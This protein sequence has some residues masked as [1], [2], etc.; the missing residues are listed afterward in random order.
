M[1]PTETTTNGRP[2]QTVD[3]ME[4]GN[5]KI[6]EFIEDESQAYF[7]MIVHSRCCFPSRQIAGLKFAMLLHHYFKFRRVPACTCTNPDA[8]LCCRVKVRVAATMVVERL[9]KATNLRVKVAQ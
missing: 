8:T 7:F 4:V 1:P 9:S 6:I 3:M 5:T 2:D